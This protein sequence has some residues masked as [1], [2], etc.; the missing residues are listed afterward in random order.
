M[1]DNQDKEPNTDEVQSTREYKKILAG[2]R[3]IFLLRNIQ[4]GS[5]DNP[6][7]YSRGTGII[8]QG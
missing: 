2:P 4:A 5:E 6:A 7:F 3:G 1:Q 8:P